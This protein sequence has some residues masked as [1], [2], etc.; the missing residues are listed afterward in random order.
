MRLDEFEIGLEFMTCT[1]Q[2]WRCTD[3]GRRTIL[4]IE[5]LP[6]LDE[7]WFSGPPYAL[8]EMCFDEIEVGQAH[9]SLEDA[10]RSA[11]EARRQSAHPGYPHGAIETMMADRRSRRSRP[12]PRSGLL[13]IDRVDSDGE[14]LHPFA[15]DAAEDSW[16]IRVYLPFCQ[17]FGA[18]PEAE[19][20][21]LRPAT[22]ADL[23]RRAARA[24]T[25]V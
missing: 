2:R 5:L 16:Q 4:A 22:E 14:I 12:Y 9:R 25:N 24:K 18:V 19:F 10:T 8:P 3:I 17:Q 21:Q 23:R 6:D 13:R 7:A 20:I 1:G 11:L 15:A